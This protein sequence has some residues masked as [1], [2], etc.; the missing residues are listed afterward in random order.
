MTHIDLAYANY[1]MRN[2]AKIALVSGKVRIELD[3]TPR[4]PICPPSVKEVTMVDR[5]LQRSLRWSF[6]DDIEDDLRRFIRGKYWTKITPLLFAQF[7]E[8]NG[9]NARAE[10]YRKLA[11]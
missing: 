10:E 4:L 7:L 8:E 5:P 6:V 1:P 9:L 11:T 3:E 2:G